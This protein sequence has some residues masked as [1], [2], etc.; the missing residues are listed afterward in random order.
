LSIKIK[1][2]YE[3]PQELQEVLKRLKPILLSCKVPK[4]QEGRFKRA[5]IDLQVGERAVKKC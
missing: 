1:V 3:S 4:L 5:Y 2:S